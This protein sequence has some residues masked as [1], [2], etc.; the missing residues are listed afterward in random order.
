MPVA[1]HHIVIDTHDLPR[2]AEFW[3]EA[4]GWQ[5]LSVRE[6][7]IVVGLDLHAPVGL[8]FMPVTDP[9]GSKNR[10]HFDL[11]TDAED[12][13]SEIERLQSLGARHVDVGQTGDESWTVLADPSGGDRVAR[14]ARTPR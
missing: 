2:L 10:L 13:E 7:E 14:P 1:I 9:K 12:R 3:A 5:I 4:L 11:N 6:R 8:C